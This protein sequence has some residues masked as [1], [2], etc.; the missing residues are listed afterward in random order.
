MSS[1]SD[2]RLVCRPALPSDTA[3]VLEFTKF[4]WEGHDYIKYVWQEWLDDPQGLLAT[5]QYGPHAVGIAKVTH[6]SP[7]QWWLEG[8][9]VNPKFQGLKIGS[10]LHEYMNRWWLRYGDGVIRLMTSSQRVQVHHL[11]E[12]TGYTKIG[13]VAG[14]RLDISG[15]DASTQDAPAIA[16]RPVGRPS[17]GQDS[18]P[19]SFVSVPVHDLGSALEFA[20]RNL[21]H[22]NALM[23]SCWRF[24][25]PDE[26]NLAALASVGH[27]HWWRDRLGLLGTFEDEDD[28]QR[29][30]AIGFAAVARPPLLAD[31]L[32]QAVALAR[33]EGFAA[34]QWL[35][36]VQNGV[37]AALQEAG[38][39][40][41]WEH[42]GYLYGKPHPGE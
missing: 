10:H 26:T 20:S 28:E 35:A 38:Y 2:P 42:T 33:R 36:P 32:R 19:P 21:P 37:R 14:Y 9:R 27:L 1:F 34:I 3:D 15:L 41:D 5:A 39:V 23:D 11:C 7:G 25:T 12:R 30:L 16:E 22:S 24:S 40:T 29:V 4:I 8:L 17:T 13:E 31:L 18:S 6:L